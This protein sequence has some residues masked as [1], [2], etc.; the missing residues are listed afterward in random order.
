[1]KLIPREKEKFLLNFVV[2]IKKRG[3]SD[4]FS[5]TI[6]FECDIVQEVGHI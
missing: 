2:K 3:D 1:M 5:S 4:L 6:L